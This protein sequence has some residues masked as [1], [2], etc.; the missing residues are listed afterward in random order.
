MADFDYTGKW[1]ANLGAKVDTKEFLK[2]LV[3]MLIDAHGED[4]MALAEKVKAEYHE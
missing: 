1:P 4:L 2:A 3:T